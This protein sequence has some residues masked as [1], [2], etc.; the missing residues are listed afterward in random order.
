VGCVPLKRGLRPLAQNCRYALPLPSLI[1]H[2]GQVG[3]EVRGPDK[4]SDDRRRR[5]FAW[6]ASGALLIVAVFYFAA[7]FSVRVEP[8]AVPSGR[9]SFPAPQT[10]RA[11]CA[12][13]W[14]QLVSPPPMNTTLGTGTRLFTEVQHNRQPLCKNTGRSR[15]LF[16]G[17]L[18]LAVL[19]LMALVRPM[20]RDA[21]STATQANE[22]VADLF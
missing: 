18:F 3:E 9:S 10:V 6:F 1:G 22:G 15:A 16:S 4:E 17:W 19:A 21:S 7:P 2:Y 8:I 11:D 20:R 12:G 14:R 5:R 13:P